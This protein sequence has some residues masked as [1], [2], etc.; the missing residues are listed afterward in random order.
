MRG[1]NPLLERVACRRRDGCGA[2]PGRT[3]YRPS[4]GPAGPPSPRGRRGL[5]RNYEKEK[6]GQADAVRYFCAG[7]AH[8]AGRTDADRR[9]VHRYRHGRHPGHP[10]HGGGRRHRHRIL[11]GGQY[12]FR[13]RRW[14]PGLYLPGFRSRGAGAGKAGLRPV[15]SG[16]AGAGGTADVCHRWAQQPHCG[17]DAGGSRHPGER[18]GLLPHS[19]PSHALP[20]SQYSLC[21][22]ASGSG[23]H[24][25]PYAGRPQSQP[26]QHCSKL[27]AHL[28]QENRFSFWHRPAPLGRGLGH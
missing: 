11:A 22:G 14:L 5:R 20:G 9:A 8:H 4:S 18:R 23:R 15:L 17:L 27:S 16:G 28:F 21:H 7:L 2:V 24:P 6:T 12:G 25:G 10:S 13:R 19:L 3:M 1:N 26:D